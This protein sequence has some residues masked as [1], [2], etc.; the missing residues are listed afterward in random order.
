MKK[1]D[2]EEVQRLVWEHMQDLVRGQVWDR[3]RYGVAGSVW[4]LVYDPVLAQV[5]GQVFAQLR[6]VHE[7]D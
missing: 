1:N 4:Q 2:V 5:S 7:R 6:R 3:A